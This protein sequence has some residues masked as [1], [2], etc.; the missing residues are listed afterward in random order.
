MVIRSLAAIAVLICL[1]RSS[2]AEDF[3][4]ARAAVLE[5]GKLSIAPAMRELTEISGSEGI[6]AVSYDALPYR[7]QPTRVFAWL[8]VPEVPAGQKVPGVVLI[9]GGGGTAYLE[10][11]KRWNQHGFAAISIAVEGQV[12]GK[13]HEGSP[14]SQQ[15]RNEWSG[16]A[17]GGIFVDGAEPLQDQWIYHAV[18]DTILARLLLASQPGVDPEKIGVC[19]IS[20]GGVVTST[21]IGIDP[22]FAFAIPIYGCGHLFD[23]ENQWGEAL[24]TNQLYREVWDPMVRMSNARLPVL[25]LTWLKDGHFPLTCQSATYKAAPGQRMVAVLPDMGHSHTAGWIPEESYAFAREVVKT[26]GLWGE[27]V[28]TV[29][30]EGR[31]ISTVFRSKQPLDSAELFLTSETGYTGTREWHSIPATL[32]SKDGVTT[33]TANIPEKSTACFLNVHAGSLT[34]STDFIDFTKRDRQE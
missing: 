32:T 27:E 2:D 28:S 20:W 18:A 25:W 6:R 10:W 8:G 33:V 34:A 4:K 12:D 31:R 13:I 30:E 14:P 21:V 24:G 11:V 5:L 22:K 19:G 1:A 17:R 29:V 26:G 23:A 9:H 3:E 7:G 16:P 15:P